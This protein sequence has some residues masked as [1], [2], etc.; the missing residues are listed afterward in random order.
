MYI[1]RNIHE[2]IILPKDICFC[3]DLDTHSPLNRCYFLEEENKLPPCIVIF[4]CFFYPSNVLVYRL[5]GTSHEATVLQIQNGMYRILASCNDHSFGA[6][7]F[8]EILQKHLASE[9]QRLVVP[10]QRSPYH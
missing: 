2:C 3:G 10:S 1:F 7:H 9:F 5:G 8:T 4:V 6:D